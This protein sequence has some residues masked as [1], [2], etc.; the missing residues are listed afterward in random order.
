MN[1]KIRIESQNPLGSLRNNLQKKKSEALNTVRL[2]HTSQISNRNQR[3]ILKSSCSSLSSH[4][5]RTVSIDKRSDRSV[6]F[7][8]ILER[9]HL[10][11]PQEVF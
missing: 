4:R 3:S 8:K 11:D 6:S 1:G 9:V 2:S 5:K 7:S 10:Y